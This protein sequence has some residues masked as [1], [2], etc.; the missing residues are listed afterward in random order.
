[1]V[2]VQE[3]LLNY[4]DLPGP[5]GPPWIGNLFQI[6]SDAFHATLDQWADQYGALHKFRFGPC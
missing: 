1:M 3:S 2:A 5:P 4:E 6:R